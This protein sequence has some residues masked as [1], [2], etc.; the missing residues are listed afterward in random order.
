M[1]IGIDCVDIARFKKVRGSARTHFLM[2]TFSVAER[3]YCERHADAN[4]HYA[5]TFAA[6]EAVLKALL[7][8]VAL[9]DVEII[10]SASG[11]PSVRVRGKKRNDVSVSMTHEAGLACAVA[12]KK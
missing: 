10:R 8:R 11:A 2:R 1:K 5:S 12:L 6:K 3:S 4:T 7:G 9:T